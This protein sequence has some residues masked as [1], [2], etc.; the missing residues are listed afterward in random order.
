VSNDSYNRYI[1]TLNK[2]LISE[3]LDSAEKSIKQMQKNTI[4][5]DFEV[6][7]RLK[8]IIIKSGYTS[9]NR[10][11]VNYIQ[12][13]NTNDVITNSLLIDRIYSSVLAQNLIKYA[14]IE[15]ATS[16]SLIY[17][18]ELL[19]S[20]TSKISLRPNKFNKATVNLQ[21]DKSEALQLLDIMKKNEKLI[22]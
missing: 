20:N 18:F 15:N 2:K 22:L 8:L 9:N 21:W 6:E 16:D 12:S 11:I 1:I 14:I 5:N 13:S 19:K 10:K 17:V 7:S 4:F 3:K